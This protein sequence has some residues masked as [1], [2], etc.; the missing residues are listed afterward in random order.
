[1]SEYSG[2][3]VFI[4]QKESELQRVSLELLGKA[5]QLADERGQKVIAALVGHEVSELVA[6]LYQYG[7][8]SVLL[9]DQRELNLYAT[10]TYTRVL[11]EMIQKEKPEICMFGA[12]AIGRDLAP[13]VAARIKTGLTADCTS[14][15]IDGD[16]GKLL[17]TRPAFGGNI[18]AT[19]ICPDHYP[20]MSTVR[21]GVMQLLEKDES[22]TGD[23][24][25]FETDLSTVSD[26]LKIIEVVKSVSEKKKIEDANILVSGGRGVGTKENLNILENLATTLGGLVSGSRAIVDQ[27]WI[28]H[29][30][31]VGQTGKQ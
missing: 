26:A 2:V 3:L 12:T 13:R 5:R 11:S 16:T 29:D 7:A 24:K 20:Q 31:Q 18:M 27:G 1:M 6:P 9:S 4:E 14:L 10:E 22:R 17:M 8:D 30:S 19:I 25:I 28:D 15:E 23:L 21:P